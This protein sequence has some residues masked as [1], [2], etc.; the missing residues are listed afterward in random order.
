MIHFTTFFALVV[1]GMEVIQPA[2]AGVLL[3]GLSPRMDLGLMKSF[4]RRQGNAPPTPPQ[5]ATTCNPVNS[6]LNSVSGANFWCYLYLRRQI[7]CG[8][9]RNARPVNVARPLSKCHTSI[10]SHAPRLQ[11]MWQITL[12]PRWSLTVSILPP[13]CCK[14]NL[15]LS[16]HNL[17]P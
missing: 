6:V 2:A 11:Q 13:P 1:G 17:Y 16:A 7:W 8:S 10:V 14:G 3:A 4:Q 5:C 15:P 12:K 9:L